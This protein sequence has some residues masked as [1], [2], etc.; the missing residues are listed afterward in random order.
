M[1]TR[2]PLRLFLVVTKLSVTLQSKGQ[3]TNMKAGGPDPDADA[4][5]A[6]F[7][8]V[9]PVARADRDPRIDQDLGEHSCCQPP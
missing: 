1:W 6:P 5:E 8:D 4:A 2:K 9:V 7:P 3:R